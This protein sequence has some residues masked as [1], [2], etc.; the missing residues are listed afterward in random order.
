MSL[1]KIPKKVWNKFSEDEKRYHEL[2]YKKAFEKNRIFTVKSTRVI[3][4]ICV[5]ALFFI[6]FTQ[7]L[8]VKEYGQIKDKYGSQAFCY[9]CGLETHKSCGCEYQSRMYEEDDYK[10]TEEYYLQLAEHNSQRCN[11]SFIIGTQGNAITGE[12]D[13]DINITFP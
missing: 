9:L 13:Y 12:E 1:S 6:G 2:E 4:V 7:L 10:L 3:A 8:A 11:A 5:L